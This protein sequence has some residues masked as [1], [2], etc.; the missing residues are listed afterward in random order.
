MM[1]YVY[2]ESDCSRWLNS[3]Q[4]TTV[5]YMLKQLNNFTVSSLT[6]LDTQYTGAWR[7][8][9]ALLVEVTSVELCSPRLLYRCGALPPRH[10]S[11]TSAKPTSNMKCIT[12]LLPSI[13][14]LTST[15]MTTDRN[16]HLLYLSLSSVDSLM[17]RKI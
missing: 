11:M 16:G 2:S 5:E 3:L 8:R 9:R 10:P 17:L 7:V 1:L 13:H 6:I 15:T 12:E 4:T 14:I